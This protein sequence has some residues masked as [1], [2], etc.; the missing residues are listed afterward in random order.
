MEKVSVNLEN[1]YGIEKLSYE[2][3]F[4]DDNVYAIYA[5]NGLMKTSLSKT[6]KK[7][8]ENKQDEIKDEIF[9]LSGTVNVKIDG[10]DITA[11]DVFVIKSFENAYESDSITSLLVNDA[12]KKN[13][14]SVLK[15]KES[16]F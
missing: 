5:R 10:T 9:D 12:T 11:K 14:S 7:I 13:I 3:D 16:C 8:Q 2:F 4:A 1:C 15:I 6:F